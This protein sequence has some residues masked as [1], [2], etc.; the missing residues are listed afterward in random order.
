MIVISDNG[1][2]ILPTVVLSPDAVFGS[3]NR[4]GIVWWSRETCPMAAPQHNPR[5]S[6]AA[7][8]IDVFRQFA[9]RSS[10]AGENTMSFPRRRTIGARLDPELAFNVRT[11]DAEAPAW[12]GPVQRHVL[13]GSP[14]SR[15]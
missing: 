4:L 14:S 1:P 15:W 13:G 10:C 8:E 9:T 5:R 3:G 7:A 11:L 2:V 12:C 6:A